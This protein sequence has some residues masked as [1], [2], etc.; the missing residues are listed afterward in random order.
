MMLEKNYADEHQQE[1]ERGQG[2]PESR[3]SALISSTQPPFTGASTD[4]QMRRHGVN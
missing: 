1:V 2:D 4:E 3:I